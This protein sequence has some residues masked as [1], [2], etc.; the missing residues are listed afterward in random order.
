MP[1][2][3]TTSF[4]PD[5]GDIVEEAYERC[6]LEARNGYDL[7]TARRSLDLL[8]MEFANRGLNL[9]TIDSQ[10][11]PLVQ[12]TATYT[13]P[14]DTIDVMDA[15]IRTNAGNQQLQAD[16][17]ISRISFTTYS[18]QPAKLTQGFPIQYWV[19][20]V[21]TPTVTFWQVPDGTQ[22]YQF[23]YFRMRRMQDVGTSISNNEDVP[24]RFIP[25]IVAG[26][27]YM[28]AVKKAPDRIDM[29]K[30]QFEEQF[31]MAADEDRERATFR[32]VP[33]IGG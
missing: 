5:V 26:L 24:F 6:G 18:Q 27:A 1:L 14:A 17:V 23:V 20:R 30:G 11:L 31:N 19:N 10:T 8:A 32:W 25:A 12:G 28:I 29:L 22:P 9:W 16:I 33:R 4:N 15:V 21:L 7:R 2:S 13:L 3:G